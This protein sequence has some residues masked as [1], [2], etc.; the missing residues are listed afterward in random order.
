M[1]G[2]DEFWTHTLALYRRTGVAAACID[3]QDRRGADVNLLLYAM[4]RA[5][6]GDGA[7][8]GDD[9]ARLDLA[10]GPWRTTVVERLRAARNAIKSGFDGVAAAEAETLRKA[11]LGQEIEG[12]R[13]A[14]GIL[15]AVSIAPKPARAADAAAASLAAYAA[16]L[17]FRPD[18]QDRADFQ[19]L[20][21]AAIPAAPA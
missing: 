5:V 14:H 6:R 18:A 1:S 17:E 11:I 4:W 8:D 21:L 20:I 3:L 10:V 13:I 2:P 16:H 9:F 7:L 15:S 12:E 19:T